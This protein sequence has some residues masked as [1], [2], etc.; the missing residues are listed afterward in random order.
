MRVGL[1]GPYALDL[2]AFLLTGQAL[3]TDLALFVEIARD[4]EPWILFAWRPT[5]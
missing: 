3:D 1:G 2:P 4:L 5:E